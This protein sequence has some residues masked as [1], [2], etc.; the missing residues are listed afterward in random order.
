MSEGEV[1]KGCVLMD[2]NARQKVPTRAY[3]SLACLP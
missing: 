2:F 1:V 3:L